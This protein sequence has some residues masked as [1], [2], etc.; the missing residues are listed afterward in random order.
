M[1]LVPDCPA[2]CVT[3]CVPGLA[4]RLSDVG[5]IMSRDQLQ[6][7]ETSG[8]RKASVSPS[9]S[10]RLGGQTDLNLTPSE[11]QTDTS[12]LSLEPGEVTI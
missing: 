2:L 12:R 7:I 1:A 9:P 11:D 5:R 8:H 4:G 10:M 6:I 3:D